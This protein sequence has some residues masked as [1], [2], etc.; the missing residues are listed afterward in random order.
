MVDSSIGGKTAI[1]VAGVKNAVGTI[2]SA[3]T[4]IDSRYLSTL[5]QSQIDNGMGEVYK[6][7][8]LDSSIQLNLDS[9][10]KLI[11]SCVAVKQ[12]IV[13]VDMLDSGIRQC[14]NMGHTIAHAIELRHNISHGQ[15]V[16][17]GCHYALGISLQLGLV[18][19]HYYEQW[20]RLAQYNHIEL[21]YADI[22]AMQTDKKNTND[23]ITL[24]LPVDDYSYTVRQFS[25][26]QL[27]DI[28]GVAC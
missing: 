20:H 11:A 21:D 4:Y 25:C 18:S 17:C 5:P 2:Y 1:N 19:Q 9:T 3:D 22:L 8:L 26:R 24:V 15:A 14:L 12:K 10:D 16:S 23:N 28:L 7:M 27:A 6:Y 13:E